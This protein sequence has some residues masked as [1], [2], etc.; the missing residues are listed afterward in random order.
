MIVFW[1]NASEAFAAPEVIDC[2]MKAFVPDCVNILYI[3]YTDTCIDTLRHYL[4]FFL[5]YLFVSY[6]CLYVCC[7]IY[8]D[9]VVSIQSDKTNLW[10]REKEKSCFR[11]LVEHHNIIVQLYLCINFVT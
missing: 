1:P 4:L 6:F 11:R 7:V 9:T 8:I 10:H 3:E 2:H 5:P